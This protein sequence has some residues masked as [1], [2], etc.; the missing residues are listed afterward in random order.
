M[1]LPQGYPP[2]A[3]HCPLAVSCWPEPWPASS[4]FISLLVAA[5]GRTQ[6]VGEG[7]WE[8][9]RCSPALEPLASSPWTPPSL[10]SQPHMHTHVCV[11]CMWRERHAGHSLGCTGDCWLWL[12]PQR[13]SGEEKAS[14][15]PFPMRNAPHFMILGSS[16]VT[17]GWVLPLWGQI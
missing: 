1:S 12:R 14:Y 7:G 13:S 3:S 17:Q 2:L 8:L 16:T 4:L 11:E 15:S 9:A 10:E 6:E 5:P